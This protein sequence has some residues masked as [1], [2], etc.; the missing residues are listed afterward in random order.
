M[1]VSKENADDHREVK[2][3]PSPPPESQ[4][5]AR[6]PLP[7]LGRRR[8][9]YL[10][11]ILPGLK[12]R[13]GSIAANRPS[14]MCTPGAEMSCSSQA[15]CSVPTAWWCDRV[16]SESTNACWTADFTRS[17]WANGRSEEHTSELQSR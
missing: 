12:L 16:P 2:S 10:A 11:T 7:Q 6:A 5:V 8:F 15:A 9:G 17:Y 3:G 14:I 4:F 1:P 13:P